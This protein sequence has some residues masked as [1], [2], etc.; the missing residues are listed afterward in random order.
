[1]FTMGATPGLIAL[2]RIVPSHYGEPHGCAHRP[3]ER[4]DRAVAGSRGAVGWWRAGWWARTGSPEPGR[5]VPGRREG[6]AGQREARLTAE[7]TALSE[8]V[9]VL[10]STPTPHSTRPSI[11]HSR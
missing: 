9:V 10:A 8:A 7:M 4:L 1:M 11:S 6:G 5:S 3:P 2:M